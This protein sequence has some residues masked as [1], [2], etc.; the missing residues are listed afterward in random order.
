MPIK[1]SKITAISDE[2]LKLIQYY[3]GLKLEAYQDS[4]KVWTIGIGT[5]VY[6]NGVKVKKGDKITKI[7]AWD[8]LWYDLTAFMKGVD[9]YTTDTITQGQY[10]ALVS[11]TYNVG[12]GNFK[13]PADTTI[14]DEFEKWKFAGGV[15]LQGLL[16]RRKAEAFLYF[17]GKYKA[18]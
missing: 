13:N 5:T 4:V 8:F 11:L 7:Q 10:D 1:K 12:T 18:F 17:N 9:A 6:P 14:K 15:A 16:K 3:E 2:C